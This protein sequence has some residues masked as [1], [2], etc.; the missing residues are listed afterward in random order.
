M[1]GNRFST[2]IFWSLLVFLIGFS[3]CKSEFERIRTSGDGEIIYKKALEF[4]EI[5]EYQKAQTLLELAITSYRGKKEAEDIYYKYAYT[6][7]YLERYI[8][9]AYYFKNFSQT[10]GASK[11]REESDFMAAYSNYRLSPTFRLDQSYTATAIDELQLFI[12]TYPSSER[13]QECNNLIDEMRL[14]LEKKAFEEGKLY[15]DL[16]YYQSAM[17]SFEN[18]LKD[19]P[20]TINAA[21]VRYLI[22]KSNYMLAEN[23]ILDKQPERYQKTVEMAVEY[24]DRYAST[25]FAAEVM[26]IMEDSKK[27]L[28][29]KQS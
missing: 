27:Q 29:L 11:L 13:V 22:I 25:S 6:Y 10:Y 3:S 9:A 17:H 24:I 21:Q 12:N 2:T 19:F 16:R 5:E 20:E 28:K 14:K 15:L 23:S 4:Y 8:L 7:Y 1:K 26:K 18:M